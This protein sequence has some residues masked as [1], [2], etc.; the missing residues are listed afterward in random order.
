M[1]AIDRIKTETCKQINK[2]LVVD[3]EP[4]AVEVITRML[5]ELEL[6]ML[7]AYGG[8]DAI[9]IARK[10]HPDLIIL[11]LMMP[12]VSGFDVVKTLKRDHTTADIPIAICTAKYLER[13][14]EEVLEGHILGVM[15]KGQLDKEKLIS[16]IKSVH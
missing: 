2:I 14:D 16:Y 7:T 9:E 15:Q 3:D 12:E 10:E 13:E 5:S 4:D 1:G 11:D 6:E 8:K